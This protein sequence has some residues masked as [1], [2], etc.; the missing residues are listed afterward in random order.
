VK[1]IFRLQVLFLL[2]FYQPV[3]A[4]DQLM[5]NWE[6]VAILP[7]DIS[8]KDA[9][10]FAGMFTGVH[11]DVIILAGGANFPDKM[12]WDGGEKQWW[13][14]IYLLEK[15]G[16]EFTWKTDFKSK[17]PIN[18]AYGS[19]VST[20]GGVIIIGGENTSGPQS[21]VY[22][23]SWNPKTSELYVSEMP[24]LPVAVSHSSAAL[25]GTKV[26][27]VAGESTSTVAHFW[28]L[29]LQDTDSK[30]QVLPLWNGPARS[31]AGLVTQ[32]IAGEAVLYL[33]GGR[34]KM[35]SG[36]SELYSD[37]HIYHPSTRTWEAAGD[38]RDA[39]NQKMTLSA[40]SISSTSS[41]H[42]LIFGGV[43][44]LYFSQL[45]KI[46]LELRSDVLDSK[47]KEELEAK[48]LAILQNHPG[49]S[50]KVF[51]YHAVTKT[52]SRL[53]DLS[54]DS[55]V[56]TM[57][58]SY[59]DEIILPSGEI[60]PG[61]RTPNIWK[62]KLQNIEA[63]GMLNSA[64]LIGYLGLLVVI[65]VLVSRKQRTAGDFFKAGGRIPWWAAGLSVF[66]TQLSAI[67][68]MAVPAKTFATD[69]TLFML[70][71]T[72]IMI[73]PLVIYLFLPFFRRLNLTTS[74][75]YLELR[76]SPLVR[77]LG[78]LIYTLLQLGRLGIVLLLP[79]LAL[80]VV[81]GIDI[82]TCILIMG[83]LSIFYTVIGGIEAV[84]WT[85]VLQVL[86][87]LSGALICL[88]FMIVKVDYSMS[89]WI[90]L[91]RDSGKMKIFDWS[92]DLSGTAVWVVLIGGLSSNLVQYGSDQTVIQRYLTTKDEASAAKGIRV[93]AWMA[94]PSALI[95]F[96]VGTALYVFYSQHPQDLP[97][98][99]HTTDSIFPWYIVTQLPQGVS[100][101]LIAAIF[102]AA[103]SS[104]DSSMNSV[105][106]VLTTDFYPRLY[107]NRDLEGAHRLSFA[108]L[109]TIVI[110]LLGT[111]LALFM[112]Q[113]GITSLWDHF[114]M[115]VGLFAG[116]LGGI[117]LVGILTS[118]AN[119]QG[120]T[121]GL[122]LSGILQF[123]V[124][125]YMP[126]S[127]HLYAF[128]GL[129]SAFVFSYLISLLFDKPSRSQIDG[130][131]YKTLK[132]RKKNYPKLTKA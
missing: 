94:L 3:L 86:V 112:V 109:I 13:N 83:L 80:S 113:L 79:S 28:M 24:P 116:G 92:F 102:A 103:M 129:I 110:G 46:A 14:D 114:N 78:S 20:P 125:F 60:S 87:L 54:F 4:G 68:F 1:I 42:I 75:E 49:F 111:G 74:Y 61:V 65:G 85:D 29:D 45:E 81:T 12:P 96:S 40:F 17:L 38:M 10:G 23:L 127:I 6:K 99:N 124:K 53:E 77:T 123:V 51:A 117:F 120:A 2:T 22:R 56:N 105:A 55:P 21:A 58:I 131:T 67:T 33:M 30:W 43:T 44:G 62:L 52:W 63:F 76:F 59:Q 73:A 70:L 101:L 48:R 41:G 132:K 57:A 66:G 25:I 82:E 118:R 84:I 97:P 93:G 121:I 106:T 27:V 47:V 50:K 98:G 7:K 18:L 31:N 107:P 39:E 119:W 130:L 9:L 35:S 104:L 36:I 88:I 19:A 26:Y 90:T 122:L 11:L 100:G 108:R 69:W 64:I 32:V 115:L 5:M 34:Q 91:A 89:D 128:V 95:F 126:L 37:I 8:G 71:M 16:E 15:S 72:I